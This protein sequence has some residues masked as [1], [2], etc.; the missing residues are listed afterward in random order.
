MVSGLLTDVA[1]AVAAAG[2]LDEWVAAS[3]NPSALDRSG[4]PAHFTASA[5]PIVPDGSRVCLV[6]HRRI[7]RW[8]QPGGHFEPEDVSVAAAAAR[9]LVEETGL[10]AMVDPTPLHLS[11][12]P[13]PC[14][15]G[16][17]HLDFQ[18][19]ARIEESVP[20]VSEESLDVAWF[21]VGELPADLAPG[22]SDLVAR[23][24]ARLSRSGSRGSS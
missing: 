24:V 9:E 22:T 5:L 16:D 8:V 10:V 20:T 13:A 19:I 21:D 1:R 17:W 2:G 18:M 15:V 12:H 23:A 7:Q 4:V 11:K 14:G 3:A 6:L